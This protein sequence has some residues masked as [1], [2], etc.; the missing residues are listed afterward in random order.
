[1]S[2]AVVI[3]AAGQG[4]RM[5]SRLSK[6]LHS[7]AGRPMLDYSLRAAADLNAS[8]TVLVLGH[9]AEQVQAALPEGV[10][11]VHQEPQLGTGHALAQAAGILG[12]S[13]DDVLV[14]YGDMPLLR[15]DTL[16]ALVGARGAAS[17]SLLTAHMPGPSGYGR[18]LRD[19]DGRLQAIVEEKE[20]SPEQRAIT[21]VNCGIYCFQAE[22]VW[23]LLTQLPRHPDGEYYLTDVVE[24]AYRRG[25]PVVAQVLPDAE[26]VYGVNNR[27]QLAHA[28]AVLRR[29]VRE[30][31]MLA[32]VTIIDPASTFIDDTVTIGVDTTLYPHTFVEGCTGIGDGCTIGP[33]SRIVDST[34]GEACRI[35]YSVVEQ[36]TLENGVQM[37]PFCHLRPGAYLC[38]GVHLGNYAEVKNSRLGPGTQMHHFSYMGD[39]MVGAGVNIA[40]GTIT[41][42]FDS[43]TQTKG[44]T[45]IED[46]V[47]IGSDTMLV[48]PVRVGREAITGA[49]S[50]VTRDVPPETVVRG[51]PARAARPVRQGLESRSSSSSATAPNSEIAPDKGA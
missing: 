50:V 43:E 35:T 20:A 3:L 23:D 26:E 31:H 8:R 10:E 16:Q 37:G 46:G 44:T 39:A 25:T 33:G 45:V 4:T 42:N 38:S 2:L 41:C 34:V 47:A 5:R 48:A 19:K 51:V 32:G 22:W 14:L 13:C 21:E 12:A 7:V 36:A 49:G 29:R 9:Q 18:I 1:M 17:G 27:I 30:R 11:T 6:V 28:D 15:S 24:L 40:A